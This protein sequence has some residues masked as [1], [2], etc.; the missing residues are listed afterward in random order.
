MG[1][2]NLLEIIPEDSPIEVF[3]ANG[4]VG[5]FV[6]R[7]DLSRLC[8]AL[9]SLQFEGEGPVCS[10][11]KGTDVEIIVDFMEKLCDSYVEPVA[12]KQS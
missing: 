5:I 4:K 8:S 11:G 6:R 3:T 10:Y 2:L 7:E 12:P 1:K 9:T